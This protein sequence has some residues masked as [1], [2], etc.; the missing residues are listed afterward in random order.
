MWLACPV[1]PNTVFVLIGIRLN[2]SRRGPAELRNAFDNSLQHFTELDEK[3]FFP[4]FF[5]CGRTAE[6]ASNG[7]LRR[8][9]ALLPA[10]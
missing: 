5:R 7:I 3:A 4:G 6:A 8:T 10:V 2:P 9:V 1:R